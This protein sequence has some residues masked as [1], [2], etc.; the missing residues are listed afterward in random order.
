MMELPCC[1]WERGLRKAY[2][3]TY[4]YI[5][6]RGIANLVRNISPDH[7][8]VR[9]IKNAYRADECFGYIIHGN[10]GTGKTVYTCII[11]SQVIGSIEE[12]EWGAPL[13]KWIKFTPREF[14]ELVKSTNFNQIWFDWDDAGYWLNRLFWYDDFVK[15]ALRYMTIQRTQFT[16]I[17]FS[18]PSLQMLPKKILEMEDII[19]VRISKAESNLNHDI[20]LSRPRVALLTVPWHS[21]FNSKAGCKFL[22]DE[23]F[24]GL[25]PD[26]FYSWYQPLRKEYLA[27]ASKNI[28]DAL[29]HSKGQAMKMQLE[30]VKE[31]LM[32]H[33]IP[34]AEVV[35]ELGE[36]VDFHSSPEEHEKIRAERK[37]DKRRKPISDDVA[38]V[39]L[40]K[41]REG[42][43][44]SLGD[45]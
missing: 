5:Y 12:P 42:I 17:M 22:Y 20:T 39:A 28:T 30:E 25:F 26:D 7:R 36:I 19:R 11:G 43:N 38:N 24:N 37:E 3:H 8:T 10:R 4:T 16:A 23:K 21:D 14:S 29:E 45:A 9:A 34:D 33:I 40:V 31:E 2:L 15:E 1:E 6:N 35:K 18:T 27:L 32:Q 13:R 44:Y 41:L